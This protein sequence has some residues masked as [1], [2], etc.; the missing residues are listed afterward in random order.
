MKGIKKEKKL[1]YWKDMDYNYVLSSFY[2]I[3]FQTYLEI[4]IG[5]YLNLHV[6]IVE[7]K[8]DRLSLVVAYMCMF[9]CAAFVPFLVF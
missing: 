6:V 1:K 3:F 5:G 7:T 2:V 4:L 8:S 9:G